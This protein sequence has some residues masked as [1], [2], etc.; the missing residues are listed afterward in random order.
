MMCECALEQPLMVPQCCT[1]LCAIASVDARNASKAAG[2]A[3]DSCTGADDGNDADIDKGD[4][5]GSGGDGGW[6]AGRWQRRSKRAVSS[7][8]SHDVAA[9]CDGTCAKL[10]SGPGPA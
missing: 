10:N 4:D 9:T 3:A 7:S 6:A 1:R 8:H 5:E 2:L